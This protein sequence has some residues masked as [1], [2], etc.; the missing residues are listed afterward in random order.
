M[1]LYFW[2]KRQEKIMEKI[3]KYK[4]RRSGKRGYIITLPTEWVNDL[5][6][7]PGESITF[8]RENQKLVLIKEK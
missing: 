1:R 6:L 5:N 4:I 2:F 7:E 3:R 8:F